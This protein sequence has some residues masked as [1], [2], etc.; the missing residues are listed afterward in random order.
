ML[1]CTLCAGF[2][3]ESNFRNYVEAADGYLNLKAETFQVE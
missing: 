2:I 3:S 1:P